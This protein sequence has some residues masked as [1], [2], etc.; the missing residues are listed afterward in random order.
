MKFF[1]VIIINIAF[2]SQVS[3][4]ASRSKEIN[5]ICNRSIDYEKCIKSFQIPKK[6][7]IGVPIRIKIRPY[8]KI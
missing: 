8:G 7:K 1:L 4:A 2:T 6:K 5:N 3:Y